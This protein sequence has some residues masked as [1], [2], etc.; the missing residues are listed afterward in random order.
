M[1][2]SVRENLLE[3]TAIISTFEGLS[4]YLSM[5][6]IIFY[7]VHV[8]IFDLTGNTH[9]FAASSTE[10]ISTVCARAHHC[11]NPTLQS[12]M[13]PRKTKKGPIWPFLFQDCRL[14]TGIVF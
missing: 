2:H 12:E 14:N 11:G 5:I 4:S 13:A 3:L 10:P 7:Y 9:S 1:N 6:Y 8:N